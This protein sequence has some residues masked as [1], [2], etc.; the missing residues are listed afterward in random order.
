MS[1]HEKSLLVS[2]NLG[3]ITSTRIDRDTTAFVL[4]SQSAEDEAGRWTAR[5]WPKEALEPIRSL[6]SRIRSYHY[7][8]TLPWLDNGHRII[9][10]RAFTH[11][12]DHLRGLR[13]EREQAVFAFLDHYPSWIDRALQMRGSAF[14]AHEYPSRSKAERKFKF[15][16]HCEPVP[17][18]NDFRVALDAP[19]MDRIQ[20]ELDDRIAEAEL[21]ARRD[22]Y[23]RIA[24][25]V[26][27]LLERLA[28]PDAR[29]TDATLNSIRDLCENLPDLNIWDDP[30]I[31]ALRDR[32]TH[33][34]CSLRP[35]S[36]KESRSD[37]TRAATKASG[38]LQ[39]MAPWLAADI[40]PEDQA[41]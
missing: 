31:T 15:D 28:D 24:A 25:P 7:S 32:I 1:L 34:L 39:S 6:D 40:A 36:L 38:I 11:Y 27:S 33:G 9:A 26:A 18:S 2:I 14:D 37:R 41:A 3:G 30:E 35:D 19:D 29:I 12:T 23:G 21:A 10:S 22:L 16:V 5:L 20:K 13:F 4:R 17:C 8:K